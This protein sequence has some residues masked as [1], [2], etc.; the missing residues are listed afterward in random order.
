[1]GQRDVRNLIID[2]K[3]SGTTVLLSSHQLSEVE[4]VCDTVSI[5][6]R[7]RVAAEGLID[8]L[9]NVAGQT[10][11]RVR[12]DAEQLPAAIADSV[13]DV[14]VSGGVWVFS[15]P[16]DAVRRTVDHLDDEGWTI[17][18]VTPKRESL[19]EYFSRL[20]ES[21]DSSEVVA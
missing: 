3:Q 1:V 15:V 18:A 20:L 13:A 9:L 19:E 12:G 8:D 5:F 7:G 21:A 11:F 2:L 17:V 16:D 6:N 10:S 4:A 14:A